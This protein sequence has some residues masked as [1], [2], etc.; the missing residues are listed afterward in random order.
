MLDFVFEVFDEVLVHLAL[1]VETILQFLK[2]KHMTLTFL[3]N[4][5]TFMTEVIVGS[6]KLGTED[7][8]L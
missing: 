5:F 2:L 4:L 1:P 7:G 3:P 8:D 6:V